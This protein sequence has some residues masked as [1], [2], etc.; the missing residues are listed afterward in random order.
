MEKIINIVAGGPASYIPNLSLYTGEGN[1]WVGVDYGV[2]HL[3][4][5]GIN[6]D[7]AFGDFDSV[8]DEEWE[9][10]KEKTVKIMEYIP[11][12]DETD[13]ELALQW[14]ITKKPQK[15]NIFGATGGRADHYFANAFLL[16][17]EDILH[18]NCEIELIDC[19]NRI[20]A[21]LPGTYSLQKI[22]DLKYISFIPLTSEIKNINLIGFKYP[23]KN[24]NVKQGTTLCISNE[25]LEDSGTFSFH[26]GILLMVRSKDI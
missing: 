16:I 1:I 6:P 25:L 8:S 12:K 10:I 5:N 4:K 18:T 26:S 2:Y 22:N 23:L 17:R 11:E 9:K 15:I 14:A 3:I 7:F 13:L 24:K 20:T 21:H 19:Q